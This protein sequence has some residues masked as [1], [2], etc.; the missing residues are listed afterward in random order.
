MTRMMFL[1]ENLKDNEKENINKEIYRAVKKLI[2]ENMSF[3][4][5]ENDFISMV[6]NLI[7]E[8]KLI[9]D[10][11]GGNDIPYFDL[12]DTVVRYKAIEIAYDIE[13]NKP[14]LESLERLV[15]LCIT[16][17]IE[18]HTD[19]L[20]DGKLVSELIEAYEKYLVIN[21]SD[22]SKKVIDLKSDLVYTKSSN[23]IWF[24]NT[25]FKLFENE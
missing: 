19:M 25:M 20:F 6:Y 16:L 23:T 17:D 4:Y 11:L 18:P 24:V 1:Y 3:E 10:L 21:I 5:S 7:L 13:C 14:S 12:K 2:L 22:I 9:N 8:N 15:R